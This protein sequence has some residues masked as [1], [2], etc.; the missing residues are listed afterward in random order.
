MNVNGMRSVLRTP[1]VMKESTLEKIL[2]NVND[3][4]SVSEKQD[5]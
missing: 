1:R 4:G 3:V 2:R 5:H